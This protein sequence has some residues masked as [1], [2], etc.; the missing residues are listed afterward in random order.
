[1]QTEI[2]TIDSFLQRIGRCARY[3]NEKGKIYVYDVLNEGDRKYLPYNEE[4]TLKTF[5]ALKEING[6]ILTSELSQ[7]IIDRVYSEET[8]IDAEANERVEGTRNKFIK[9]SWGLPDKKRFKDLIRDVVGCNIIIHSWIWDKCSPY[10]FE[11]LGLSPWTLR[12]EVKEMR[13]E[14]DD[15]LV[16]EVIERADDSEIK[17]TYRAIEA[18]DIYPNNLY[19]L[20]P[21]YFAYDEKRGLLFNQSGSE[22]EMLPKEDREPSYDQNY[23][24]E[25][26]LE[27][28][29]RMK[30][31]LPQL[32]REMSHAIN[33]LKREFDLSDQDFRDIVEFTIWAHDLG[34]LQD[35]WQLAHE[36][37]KYDFVAHAK[38]NK[39]PPS[40]AAEGFWIV[41]YLLEGFVFDYL[42]KDENIIDIIGKAIISH[43]SLS[44]NR[45]DQYKIDKRA[46]AYL[47]NI[48]Q[49]FFV[50]EE[51]IKFINDKD[52]ILQE[53]SGVDLLDEIRVRKVD[54]YLFYFILVRLL[55]L[56]DQRATKKLNEGI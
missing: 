31:E 38:R 33:L 40:H 14:T 45:T 35:D 46:A 51:L 1:M 8:D 22:F 32:E 53:R 34:K 27:H 26:Y 49:D 21:D 10:N 6:E 3:M 25:S 5:E 30:D 44:V 7:K 11:S 24:E 39:K 23:K 19:I 28:I 42:G 52:L 36:R 48:N 50:E 56:S 54:Q 4:A 43:H 15:W 37:K 2:S 18:D 47:S 20:N 17:Y 12:K 16:K 41:L 9:E 55:R 13:V 29:E